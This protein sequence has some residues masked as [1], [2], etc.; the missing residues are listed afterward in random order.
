[1]LTTLSH[2]SVINV[3]RKV[4]GARTI[5]VVTAAGASHE[6]IVKSALLN[7]AGNIAGVALSANKS[8]GRIIWLGQVLVH[9]AGILTI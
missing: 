2:V 5:E 9:S 8:L 1:M 6:K 3:R 4:E 7:I